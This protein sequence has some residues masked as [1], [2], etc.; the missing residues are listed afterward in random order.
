M[1]SRFGAAV[2]VLYFL[3][4]AATASGQN[5]SEF[6]SQGKK[7]LDREDYYAAI[8]YFK[9]AL[10]LNNTY[11]EPLVGLA[12]GYFAISEYEEALVHIEKARVL[13]RLN[14]ALAVSE[15]RIRLGLGQ[16]DEARNV[17][18]E[19]LEKEPNNIDAQFGLAE[20][21]IAF[22][23]PANAAAL[24]E[25]ALR[26]SPQN[27]RALLSLVLV[28]DEMGEYEVS[29]R[30][31]EQVLDYYP[32][33]ATVRYVAAK[34]MVE[35]G[36]YEDAV[37]HARVALTVKPDY[38]DAT[39]L[40]SRVYLLQEEFR[41]AADVLEDVLARFK[42]EALI[43]YNL[44]IAYTRLERF[45]DA[46]QAYARVFTIQPDDEI[47]RIAL[48][49][50]LLESTEIGDSRRERFAGYHFERGSAFLERN[51]LEKALQEFRRGLVLS[52]RSKEG[53]LLYAMVYRSLGLE[54]K[55]YS[56][57]RVLADLG[58]KD[59]EIEN[60]LEIAA[61]LLRDTVSSRWEISQYDLVRNRYKVALYLG[62]GEMVHMYGNFE[63][64]KYFNHLLL[65]YDKLDL[66]GTLLVNTGFGAAFNDAR[67]RGAD[68][69]AILSFD[70]GTR[71]FSASWELFSG[72]TGA[73]LAEYAI[74]RTGN[75]RVADGLAGAARVFAGK[76]PLYAEIL[77]REFDSVLIDAGWVD[78]VEKNDE[79][80]ILRR[81]AIKGTSALPD[82]EYSE[83]DVL[84]SVTISDIDE[85]IAEGVIE[86]D[87]FFDLINVGDRVV[88][89]PQEEEEISTVERPISDDLYR[90]ILRI[91]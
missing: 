6:Y 81:E 50:L 27:R 37:Y 49:N 80:L 85:L 9:T 7:A 20:L 88:Y 12:D 91:R 66:S 69:F 25:K 42:D 61:S 89:P 23:K 32:Q 75:N 30:Y 76:F 84:G 1:T 77:A 29:G 83:E 5:A 18:E 2:F 24:Y 28:F 90:A 51:Y 34:H 48:E 43:W 71:H 79:L 3:V 47:A 74:L 82:F 72:R 63:I 78:G 58:L 54:G 70:E 87:P 68:Y 26:I 59:Q 14:T 57:L 38:L 33:N 60:R 13:D 64:G 45:D 67:D 22:G 11:L 46:V 44:G 4:A 35:Q 53:R 52:P 65:S 10:D 31:L 19:V 8:E 56:E 73:R 86:K 41:M 36:S 15:G 55:Y 40:L 16:F 39:L 21:S 62:G 17:F